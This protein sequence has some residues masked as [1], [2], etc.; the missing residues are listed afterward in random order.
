VTDEIDVSDGCDP[1]AR[2]FANAVS[3]TIFLS[4]WL[5]APL[6]LGLII[7]QGVY[8]LRF[9]KDL[10][11]LTIGFGSLDEDAIM[12]KVLGLVD[13]VMIANLLIM[14]II[15]GY[16][17]FVSRIR[18]T[19]HRDKPQWLSHVNPNVLKVKLAM[20]I[21]GISSVNL[22]RTFIKAED[23]IHHGQADVLKWQMVIHIAFIASAIGLGLIDWLNVISER[24]AAS[25]HPGAPT[26]TN[27]AL[28]MHNNHE[29][30]PDAQLEM[31]GL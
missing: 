9:G 27:G 23:Y 28:A 10:W 8:V 13:V 6:Y 29:S 18:T 2:T 11:D 26:H 30:P 19:G 1:A 16:E 5:Q 4:R 20:S 17:T 22:L 7:A 15:G 14:V 12:L 3:G 21:I 25:P 31:V 24:K